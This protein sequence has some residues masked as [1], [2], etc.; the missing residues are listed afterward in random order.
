MARTKVILLTILLIGAASLVGFIF[1]PQTRSLFEKGEMLTDSL[2][3]D[4]PKAE[5]EDEEE[6]FN[7]APELTQSQTPTQSFLVTR[8]VD[9]DTVELISGQRVRYIGINTPETVDPRKKVQ[10][11]GKEATNKNKDL[12]EGKL[13]RL[14]K[15]V[16]ETD[17]FGRL[18][19]YVY[20]QTGSGETFVNDLLVRE[21]FAH[22]SPFPPDIAK[23]DQLDAAEAEARNSNRGL[24]GSCPI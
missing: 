3:P 22:S 5:V 20:L 2:L 23:Q 14:E 15:D 10:C 1:S 6:A 17:R 21:G 8:V 24:W 18:L 7:T 11:F 9:G 19:R 16:S 4:E 12:V 13:V